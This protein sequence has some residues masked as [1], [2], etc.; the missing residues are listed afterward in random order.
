MPRNANFFEMTLL[1]ERYAL[2]TTFVTKFLSEAEKGLKWTQKIH[3][4]PHRSKKPVWDRKV[5]WLRSWVPL[6]RLEE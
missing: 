3:F 2:D 6:N 5:V 1:F 4:G